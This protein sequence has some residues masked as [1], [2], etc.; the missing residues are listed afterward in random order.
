MKPSGQSQIFF[1]K[2]FC[3]TKNTKQVKTNWEK[4]KQANIKQQ[5]QQFFFLRFLPFKI[6]Y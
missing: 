5:K 6:S 4:N 1:K 3:D 2:T